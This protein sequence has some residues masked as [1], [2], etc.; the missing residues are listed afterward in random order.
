MRRAF[1]VLLACLEAALPA[2]SAVPETPSTIHLYVSSRNTNSVKRF[3]GRSGA[4]VGDFVAE[5]AGGLRATQE[6]AF[7]P[8]GQL[9]VSGRGN[10]HIL[11]FDG[12][13]GGFLGPFTSGYELDNPT[14]M[15]FGP[16]GKLYVSQWGEKRAAVAR[17]DARTG[18][19]VDEVTPPLQQGM[20]HAWDAQRVLHVASYGSRDV[21]RFGPDGELLGVL[22]GADR[23]QSAVNLW[24]V[25]EDLFVA[26]WEAGAIKRFDARTGAYRSDF[27]TGMAKTEGATFGP[28]G[29]LYVCDWERS[30]INR[31]DPSDGSFLGV[32]AEGGGMKQPNGLVFHR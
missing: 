24:F 25:G 2:R 22:V 3:D 32:F 1:L 16:D 6:V 20:A 26:D 23:L 28:D 4:F 17:F 5:G 31:Y 30:V 27:V 10:V 18:V 9:Y 11:R 19:F 8:D 29:K 21:R 7:G 14:K 12:E 15:T 13:T